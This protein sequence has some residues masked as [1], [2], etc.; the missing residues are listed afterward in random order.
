MPVPEWTE[1]SGRG[2]DRRK[3]ETKTQGKAGRACAARP[4]PALHLIAARWRFCLKPKLTVG[5]LAVSAV[6]RCHE[7]TKSRH[8]K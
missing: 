6:V 1:H 5:R 3:A 7:A 8:N 2:Q 4:N